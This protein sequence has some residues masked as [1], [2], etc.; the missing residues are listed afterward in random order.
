NMEAVKEVAYQLRMRNAG[1]I[2]I[3]DLIDMDK[4][5]NR[6]K[7]YREL[8]TALKKDKAKTN[9]LRISE[10]GLIQMTRKRTRESLNHV[11][12]EPCPYCYG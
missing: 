7:V 9:I 11:L 8:E 5:S 4:G 3:I 2:I 10:L 1:G 6:E 12:C